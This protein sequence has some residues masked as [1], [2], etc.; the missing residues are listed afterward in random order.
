ME[1]ACPLHYRLRELQETELQ[2]RQEAGSG[3][4][5]PLCE[6]GSSEPLK[7][8]A[9]STYWKDHPSCWVEWNGEGPS[10]KQWFSKVTSLWTQS[11]CRWGII[12]VSISCKRGPQYLLGVCILE[13]TWSRQSIKALHWTDYVALVMFCSMKSRIF[14]NTCI[15]RLNTYYIPTLYQ[16]WYLALRIQK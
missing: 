15:P 13:S 8:S 11:V 9:L 5:F 14:T 16:A 10:S 12:W 4:A 2:I 1:T 3:G 7:A 6:K